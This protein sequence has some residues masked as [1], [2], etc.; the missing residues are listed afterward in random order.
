MNTFRELNPRKGTET[1]V[2]LYAEGVVQL[3]SANLIPERGL[4]PIRRNNFFSIYWVLSANLIPE[5]G[6]KQL[7]F[8]FGIQSRD[9]LSAN[10]IPERGL[11]LE[12]N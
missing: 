5:R 8:V 7:E 6:L 1:P 4:K 11:K 3:L 9:V 2:K 10:L 12:Q